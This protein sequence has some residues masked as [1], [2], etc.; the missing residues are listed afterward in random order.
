VLSLFSLQPLYNYIISELVSFYF[1]GPFFPKSHQMELNRLTKTRD[2]LCGIQQ[3]YT[4]SL[5][6][7]KY[8]TMNLVP[9]AKKV[10]PLASEQQLMYPR[11]GYGMNNASIDADSMLRNESSF[12]SNRCQIRAQ[13]RPFLTVP[14]MGG[15]RG[16]PDVESML[17]HSEQV[18]QMKECG[19]IAEQQFEGQWTP[20]VKSLADNIQ[21]PKNL[22]TESAA[23]GWIR[24][25]IPSRAY[26]RDVNC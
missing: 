3:Y 23:A 4:Q 14:F 20:M 9:D 7:G 13:A 12:K 5:G 22:V 25:G 18:K 19:T 16:N 1:T 10:N 11:E 17:L 26:M 24:G 8:T 2:D 6:P 15:G 21:N